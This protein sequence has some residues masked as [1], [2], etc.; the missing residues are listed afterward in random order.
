MEKRPALFVVAALMGALVIAGMSLSLSAAPPVRP[1]PTPGVPSPEDLIPQP[2]GPMDGLPDLVVTSISVN[3]PPQLGV[4][5]TI[6][7]VIK[8]QGS[9]DVQPSN[10]FLVDLYID[11][12]VPPESGR[13]GQP[14]TLTQGVQGYLLKQGANVPLTF[15]YVFTRT[16]TFDLYAQVDTDGNVVEADEE[17]NVFGPVF[18]PVRT[19]SVFIDTRHEDF[20]AGFS[21]M[22][23]SHP[24]GLLVLSGLYEEPT[25]APLD[26]PM[27]DVLAGFHLYNPDH[28]VSDHAGEVNQ[29]APVITRDPAGTLFVA[30]EDGR[31]GEVY[32][33]DIYFSSSTDGGTSWSS[34]I[35]VNQD[36]AGPSVNQRAPAI[37]YDAVH[38]ALYIAWQDNRNGDYD[39]WFARSTDG[40]ATWTEPAS[41]PVND[42]GAGADQSQPSLVVDEAGTAYLVWQDRRHGNDDIYFA[43]SSDAGETWTRNILVTDHPAST[44]QEQRSPAITVVGGRI[45]IAWEDARSIGAGDSGDIYFTWGEACTPP[46]ADYSFHID[47]RVNNDATI[48]PQRD[49]TIIHTFP[50]LEITRTEVFTPGSEICASPPPETTE[51]TFHGIYKGRALH[52]AWQD[53]RNGLNDPDIYYAWTFEPYFYL[54]GVWGDPDYGCPPS[55]PFDP[56]LPSP[57][58]PDYPLFGNLRVNDIPP[59]TP[60]SC[61][62][63]PYGQG[64]QLP[65]EPPHDPTL[66]QERGKTLWPYAGAKQAYPAF[67]PGPPGSDTLYI[68]WSDWRNYD[69]WNADI[70]VARPIREDWESPDYVVRENLIVNDNAK[71]MRYL[72]DDAYLYGAPASV[73][74]YRPAGTYHDTSNMPYLVWDDDR[75]A[76]P[77]AGSA[78]ERNIFF[79]RPGSPPSPGVYV[80][81]IFE[82]NDEARW[83]RLEWWGVTPA[84]T[85]IFFQTR[86][87]DTPWPDATWSDWAGP[88]WDSE[89]SMWVY[90][91][92]DD[93][94]DEEGNPY[95]MARYFQYRVWIEDCDGIWKP[96][97]SNQR[98]PEA[99]I[100]KVVIHFS[101]KIYTAALPLLV[102]G[103]APPAE[104]SPTSTPAPTPTLTP[105]P[106]PA[107]AARIPNDT[108]YA[109]YQWNLPHINLPNAW[110]ITVGS[111]DVRIGVVDTGIDAGHPDLAGKVVDGYDFVNDD[112]DPSDDNGHGT[113]VAGIL[114][115]NTDNTRGVAGV[116]WNAKLLSVKALNADGI[117]PISDVAAGIIWAADHGAD[118]INLSVGVLGPNASLQ[119]A[120]NYAHSRGALL[121]AA[122]GNFYGNGNPVVYPAAYDNVL[123]VGSIGDSDEHASYSETGPYLDLVAPGGNPT[124]STD[125]NRRHW[126]LSTYWRGSSYGGSPAVG[127][128]PVAGTSQAAPHVAGVAAL[129]M[130]ADPGLTNVLTADLLTATAVDLGNTGRDDVFGYGRVDALAALQEVSTTS[131]RETFSAGGEE[132]ALHMSDPNG[133][134]PYVPGRVLVRFAPAAAKSARADALREVGAVV[135]GE[136]PAIGWYI[137]EV[138][139]G[140]E[141]DI[142]AR[143]RANPAVEYAELDHLAFLIE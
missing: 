66:P 2:A 18:I 115:A 1:T 83:N 143:L 84:G 59:A 32:N 125:T 96:P 85:K 54:E 41:N 79:A 22:D 34:D 77:L 35:R 19:S 5:A 26:P 24:V 122:A 104:W 29:I 142:L 123:A 68:L 91:A 94:V 58:G 135:A 67:S 20:Q 10:N 74:Q 15:E 119:N 108:Y 44:A 130:A 80:S 113:H 11:P 38:G 9:A 138:E 103:W 73:R 76:D 28:G 92:P 14:G 87:G 45:Y 25:D 33:R 121:V 37:A 62:Q 31:N 133:E 137:L 111:A 71:L 127:Y 30:W 49:P 99:W 69:A 57:F 97:S 106:R 17:N 107:P 6:Q 136:M 93:I 118:V 3:P 124:D 114:S 82:A 86:C 101:P 95:P 81:R 139:E 13:P 27:A 40:G 72:H 64:G 50:R 52:F 120:V 109:G 12:P 47:R 65:C 21:N 43:A 46:C 131:A 105:T 128:M 36:P 55:E 90:T 39:I 112:A 117:G 78:L 126:I 116:A 7:V 53:Y 48:M 16:Q 70:Y 56:I 63:P 110:G 98:Y 134:A 141:R 88:V 8:N 60:E 51:V 140:A 132:E 102:K 75:R 23:L 42:D 89:E 61:S 129:V 4:T 100:S